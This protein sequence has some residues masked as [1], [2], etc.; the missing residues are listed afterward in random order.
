MLNLQGCRI[1]RE[2]FLHHAGHG[3]GLDPQET[4]W[5]IPGSDHVFE[6]GDVV[7]VEPACY[8]PA[9]R[10]GVRLE[11][12]YSGLQITVTTRIVAALSPAPRTAGEDTGA[13]ETLSL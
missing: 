11:R 5:I 10:A 7:A 9:L 3:I 6:V 12:N 4:P 1:V 13:T 2:S 8:S